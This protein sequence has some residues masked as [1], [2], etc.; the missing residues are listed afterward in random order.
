MKQSTIRILLFLLLLLSLSTSCASTRLAKIDVSRVEINL[1][2]R[3]GVKDKLIPGTYYR[4]QAIIYDIEGQIIEKP[5][6]NEVVCVSTDGSFSSIIHQDGYSLFV[7]TNAESFFLL[8]IQFT[9]EVQLKNNPFPVKSFTWPVDWK[10]YSLINFRGKDGYSGSNGSTSAEKSAAEPVDGEDGEAGTAGK[11]VNF[12][13]AFYQ[14]EEMVGILMYEKNENLLFFMPLK[15]PLEAFTIDTSGGRGGNGGNG[16]D[17]GNGTNGD[18]GRYGGDGGDGGNG[19]DGGDI[20]VNFYGEDITM[21]CLFKSDGGL[22]GKWGY[23]GNGGAGSEGANSGNPGDDGNWGHT[24]RSGTIVKNQLDSTESLFQGISDPHFTRDNILWEL[25]MS[26]R[27]R[28]TKPC[29]N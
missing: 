8:G 3:S 23:G 21:F 15:V 29:C 16:S 9:L 1:L 10:F 25:P 20:T 17:G 4:V 14:H 13:M 22:Q 18:I 2:Y 26:Y 6:Y 11:S 28:L 12:D 19:G 24:G 27:I 7:L 5:D